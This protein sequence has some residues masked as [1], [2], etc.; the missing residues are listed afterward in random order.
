MESVC[1]VSVPGARLTAV[2]VLSGSRAAVNALEFS[3]SRRNFFLSLSPNCSSPEFMVAVLS[4]R[5]CLARFTSPMPRASVA[6]ARISAA[7]AAISVC[8]GGNC[9]TVAFALVLVLILFLVDLTSEVVAGAWG[10]ELSG[11][12][13]A[14]S[15][16]VVLCRLFFGGGQSGAM[17]AACALV[18]LCSSRDRLLAV[19]EKLF[20][21][22]KPHARGSNR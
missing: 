8:P 14:N 6:N 11:N 22:S 13:D 7:E 21:V 16:A 3:R 19:S 10:A 17:A 18:I 1:V 4:K 5:I 20:V 12:L 2:E 15:E 9:D